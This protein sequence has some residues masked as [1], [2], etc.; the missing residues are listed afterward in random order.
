MDTLNDIHH[1]PHLTKVSDLP[2]SIY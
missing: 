1:K 2:K